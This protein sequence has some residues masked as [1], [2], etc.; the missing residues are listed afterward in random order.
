M[1]RDDAAEA[2][3]RLHEDR[4]SD[5]VQAALK[6]LD[7]K[8]WIL[9][10]A[11]D[12]LL[13][14]LQLLEAAHL[15]RDREDDKKTEQ[16]RRESVNVILAQRRGYRRL[17]QIASEILPETYR[18]EVDR[19]GTVRTE[20]DLDSGGLTQL[21]VA[22]W[23]HGGSGPDA[24]AL[25]KVRKLARETYRRKTINRADLLAALG[26]SDGRGGQDTA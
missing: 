24:I 22:G 1:A 14:V 3:Q 12:Y 9:F 5:T 20:E 4:V 6:E 13:G 26:E 11:K 25:A 17:A 19:I 15:L 7:E 2:A 10:H 23:A 21:T 18:A 16:H 8:R